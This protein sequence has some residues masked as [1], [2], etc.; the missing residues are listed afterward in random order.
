M[1]R[2]LSVNLPVIVFVILS[3]C[4]LEAADAPVGADAKMRETLR[5][6]MLQLRTA[7]A[8]K[9]TLQAAQAA[10]DA[11]LKEAMAN[12]EKMTKERTAAQEESE[13]AIN[14]LKTKVTEQELELARFKEALDKWQLSQRQAAD[15]AARKEAERAKLADEKIVLQ[16]KVADQQV[17]NDA[18]FKLGNE[19]LTRYEKFG[20]GD[21][22]TSREPFVG[23]TRVKFQSLI[24]DF[25]DK[26]VDQKIKP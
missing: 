19:I 21:A 14:S 1:R 13:K 25:Q 18:M 11:K 7:E 6:T 26:L 16:R 17:K 8:E 3:T 24:Q 9:A 5:N 22:L 23:I 15:L 2:Q 4:H 12:L 10:N 20:L